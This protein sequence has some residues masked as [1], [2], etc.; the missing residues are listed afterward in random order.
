MITNNGPSF[1]RRTFTLMNIQFEKEKLQKKK[2]ENKKISTK[3]T[4]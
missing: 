1:N 2:N 3:P 4:F